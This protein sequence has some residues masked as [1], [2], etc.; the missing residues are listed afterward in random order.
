MYEDSMSRPYTAHDLPLPIKAGVIG[1][2]SVQ[3]KLSELRML[4]VTT[5]P[6]TSNIIGRSGISEPKNFAIFEGD[7]MF[8]E[9]SVLRES[10]KMANPPAFANFTGVY[11]PPSIK[12]QREFDEQFLFMGF[13]VNSVSR[14]EG[15]KGFGGLAVAIG[16]MLSI[17]NTSNEVFYPGDS[18]RA[19]LPSI[20]EE[21]RNQMYFVSGARPSGASGA[22]VPSRYTAVPRKIKAT[23]VASYFRDVAAST[24]NQVDMIDIPGFME[25]IYNT[26]W[27]GVS[28]AAQH[29]DALATFVMYVSYSAIIA[30]LE[31]GYIVPT[32]TNPTSPTGIRNIQLKKEEMTTYLSPTEITDPGVQERADDLKNWILYM[33]KRLGL[34]TSRTLGMGT[35]TDRDANLVKNIM[36]RSLMGSLTDLSQGD[37]ETIREYVGHEFKVA[38]AGP[39]PA[40]SGFYSSY[41]PPTPAKSMQVLAESASTV[42]ATL[43]GK[44]DNMRTTNTIGVAVNTSK[45]G[46]PLIV[47]MG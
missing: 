34:L 41:V 32:T 8:S 4:N 40:K 26:T 23:S 1:K 35:V 9:K 6:P 37:Y 42:F 33:C 45:P 19:A 21:Q 46:T 43:L 17:T 24:I 27:E 22:Q 38:P 47:Y 31:A 44:L 20:N 2:V 15:L 10:K 36:A 25:S 30:A 12:T 5:L 16:G 11:V 39:V 3:H 18:I 29:R 14:A 7:M 28:R 13:A